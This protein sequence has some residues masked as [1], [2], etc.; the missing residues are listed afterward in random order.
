MSMKLPRRS[1]EYTM[2]AFILGAATGY[3]LGAQAGR[4][5]YEQIV[6]MYN[7]IAGHPAVQGAAGMAREKVTGA[8]TSKLGFI[9]LS[10]NGRV[11]SMRPSGSRV[12]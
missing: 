8:V 4:E 9:G 7:Q 11:E 5:R 2:M 3:V 12:G 1:R 10:G 6:R